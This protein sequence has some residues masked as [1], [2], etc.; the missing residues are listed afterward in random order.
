MALGRLVVVDDRSGAALER[1]E[2]AEHRRPSDH[3]EV[4]RGIERHHTCSRICTNSVGVAG[5]AGMPRA[6]AE[7]RW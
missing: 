3:L 1:L 6:S 5:G 7:Y 2:R 4:E